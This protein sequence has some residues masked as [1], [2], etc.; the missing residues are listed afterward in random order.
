MVTAI[1]DFQHRIVQAGPIQEGKENS[2]GEPMRSYFRHHT[3]QAPKDL[4]RYK[5][6]EVFK[7]LEGDDEA[8]GKVKW[9]LGPFKNLLL[10]K[11]VC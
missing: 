9:W 2:T 11:S 8:G 5:A 10:K 7:G 6:E 1:I 4:K 3:A